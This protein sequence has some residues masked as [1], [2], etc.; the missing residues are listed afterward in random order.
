MSACYSVALFYLHAEMREVADVQTLS[1]DFR[2]FFFTNQR[3]CSLN[4][5]PFIR[6]ARKKLRVAL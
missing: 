5:K 4:V 6:R 1:Q 3:V 2:V